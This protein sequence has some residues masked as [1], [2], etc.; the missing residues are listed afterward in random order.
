MAGWLCFRSG[1]C[2]DFLAGYNAIVARSP[3]GWC[4]TLKDG[5]GISND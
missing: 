1:N 2:P 3:V 5:N 4:D